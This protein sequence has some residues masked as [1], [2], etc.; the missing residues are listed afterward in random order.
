MLNVRKTSIIV[1]LGALLLF[2]P[3]IIMQYATLDRMVSFTVNIVLILVLCYWIMTKAPIDGWLAR[4]GVFSATL[5]LITII[6]GGELTYIFSTIKIFAA[7][8]MWRQ[9][10][11]KGK[12]QF[13]SV[14]KNA[15]A[16]LVIAN[17]ISMILFPEGLIQLQRVE[18]EWNSYNVSWWLFGN[19]NSMFMWI[20]ILNILAQ[21]SI[22]FRN[23]KNLSYY[24]DFGMIIA[25]IATA[26]LSKSSTTII[27][28][29]LISLVPLMQGFL[30]TRFGRILLSPKFIVFGYIVLTVLLVSSAQLSIF[31]VVADIFGKDITFT[32]RTNAWAQAVI[33]V[34]QKPLFGYGLI[35]SETSKI[36]L[37]AYAFVNAH[38]TLMQTLINGG[39]LL[40]IQFL[41]MFYFLCKRMAG[42]PEQYGNQQRLLL[43]AMLVL[44]IAMSFEAYTDSLMFWNLLTILYYVIE[45]IQEEEYNE[46]VIE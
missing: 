27:A 9:M 38:N 23:G 10:K 40:G 11:K 39:V 21:I 33:L 41:F 42:L 44:G 46:E 3:A 24:V 2:R 5:I 6:N 26:F 45:Y 17:L 32:G 25:T 43:V 35:G 16:L 22:F 1:F 18:N 15:L 20:F 30:H 13:I 7:A 31:R 4:I 37:G 19:K 8:L 28:I 34:V 12:K 14:V 36:L 29:I